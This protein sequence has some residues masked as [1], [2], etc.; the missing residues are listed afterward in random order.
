[1]GIRLFNSDN[2]LSGSFEAPPNACA[3]P[4]PLYAGLPMDSVVGKF[5]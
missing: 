4:G 5:R 2:H 1:M 3:L